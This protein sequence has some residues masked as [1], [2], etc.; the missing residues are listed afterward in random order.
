MLSYYILSLWMIFPQLWMNQD[1]FRIILERFFQNSV[2]MSN[3]VIFRISLSLRNSFHHWIGL[4]LNTSG[5]RFEL[6]MLK[7]PICLALPYRDLTVART[8][9]HRPGA[10]DQH[11][12]TC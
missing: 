11:L 4:L 7:R 10:Q 2:H 8:D 3:F 9:H 6:H 1:G 12:E 5:F